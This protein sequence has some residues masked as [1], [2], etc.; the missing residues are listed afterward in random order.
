MPRLRISSCIAIT[1]FVLGA[2]LL[3]AESPPQSDESRKGGWR[4]ASERSEYL[5]MHADNPVEW[6]PWGDEA[7]ARAKELDRPILLSIGYASCHWCHVMRREAFSDAT[8]AKF[9][10][11][12]YVSIKVDREDLPHVD[13]VYMAAVQTITQSGGGWPLTAFL[14]PEKKPFFGGT[15]FPLEEKFGQPAFLSILT[16][17]TKAWQT[18]R[19]QINDASSK[20]TEQLSALWVPV[21]GQVEARAFL[22]KGVA[23]AAQTFDPV[24]GGARGQ[25]KF[26]EPRLLN[27][28]GALGVIEHR[29]DLRQLALTTFQR[30]ARGGIF[31]QLGGG[32]HRYTVDAE[33]RVPHF[34]KMLYSQGL[35]TEAYLEMY[36]FTRHEELAD[37]ARKTLDAMLRDFGLDEGGFA[38]SWDADTGHEEGTYYL[39][40]PAQVQEVIGDERITQQLCAYLGITKE[41]NFEGNR[42]VPHRARTITQLSQEL[43]APP[44]V[45]RA[46]LEEGVRKLLAARNLRTPPMRDDKCILGW[47]AIAVS[48]LARGAVV[49]SD[50]RYVKAAERAM[51]FA[52]RH[53]ALEGGFLRRWSNGKAD[54]PATLRDAAL[55]LKACLDLYE[56]TF[57]AKHVGR[58]RKI[59]DYIVAEHGPEKV[60][61]FFETPRGVDVLVE[62]RRVVVDDALPAGNSVLARA[63]LRLHALTGNV[64]DRELAEGILEEGMPQLE[65]RPHLAPELLVAA[66]QFSTTTPQVA[67]FGDR[68]HPQTHAL[69]GSVLHGTIPFSVVALRPPGK[70]GEQAA[71]M[72]PLLEDKVAEGNRPTAY[73]C[74][75]FVCKEPLSDPGRFDTA[76]RK[77]AIKPKPAASQPAA[78]PD[79]PKPAS[80]PASRP[81]TR[82][83]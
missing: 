30:M 27:L 61:L 57:D 54:H 23:T 43:A 33:W 6:Y 82:K 81:T 14:T 7:F 47:N 62:R 2:A 24:Q 32:F 10:N 36:R 67:V 49:L 22:D 9:L 40:T 64:R 51:A 52:D 28:F 31:D 80:Q 13:D 17:I 44:S 48:A 70:A 55:H 16:N 77:A 12:N 41:G 53:L 8:V 74:F 50:G 78:Q 42:S 1:L 46:N 56:A 65:A 38:A 20:I 25:A 26:P 59:A 15:Y 18:K 29:D 72:I 63:L 37:T 68:R 34:E 71:A 83:Q 69:L 11:D 45:L 4:L 58:A 39:W 75:D 76:L 21:A 5:R 60:G 3:F 73:L 66:L 19:T 79:I 35:L